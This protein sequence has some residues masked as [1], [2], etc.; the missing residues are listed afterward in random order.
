MFFFLINTNH[1]LYVVCMCWFPSTNII[2]GLYQANP[3]GAVSYGQSGEDGSSVST[4]WVLSCTWF[5]IRDGH[6]RL[7]QCSV[8]E[9][10]HGNNFVLMTPVHVD[11]NCFLIP[12]LWLLWYNSRRENGGVSLV[13]VFCGWCLPNQF[14]ARLVPGQEEAGWVQWQKLGGLLLD[15]GG[16]QAVDNPSPLLFPNYDINLYFNPEEDIAC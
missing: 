15:N 6:T 12:M 9:C 4:L 2:F 16:S 14:W 13:D 10:C 3:G 5:K 11:L 7:S 1:P 8:L